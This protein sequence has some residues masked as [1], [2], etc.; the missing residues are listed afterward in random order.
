MSLP[1]RVLVLSLSMALAGASSVSVC[2]TLAAPQSA[3]QSYQ[4]PTNQKISR[5]EALKIA[6]TQVPG[7]Q[8]STTIPKNFPVPVY[9]SNVSKT[10]FI[11]STK[12]NPSASANIITSDDPAKVFKWYQAVCQRDKWK[13]QVPTDKLRA[14]TKMDSNFYML[15]ATKQHHRIMIYCY[16]NPDPRQPGS[17]VNIAWSIAGR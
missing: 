5:E 10:N 17:I 3:N 4:Q 11:H 8:H 6:R 2:P 13:M 7:S 12:G 16:K 9:T 1:S 14:T 15:D